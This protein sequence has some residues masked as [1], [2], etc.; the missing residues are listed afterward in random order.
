MEGDAPWGARV[1]PQDVETFPRRHIRH[2]HC[3]VSMSGSHLGPKTKQNN[4]FFFILNKKNQTTYQT[5]L[6][7]AIYL[8]VMSISVPFKKK[9]I[10]SQNYY[11]TFLKENLREQFLADICIIS[12]FKLIHL[13]LQ[14]MD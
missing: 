8:N 6:N 11:L 9:K 7:Y 5:I 4:C 2:P 13:L 1:A 10:L 14:L 12:S 3:V